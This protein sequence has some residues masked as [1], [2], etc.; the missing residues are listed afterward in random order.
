V[1]MGQTMGGRVLTPITAKV[2]H[3]TGKEAG[4]WSKPDLDFPSTLP[5]Q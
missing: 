2:P 5:A 4:E 3:G 1:N